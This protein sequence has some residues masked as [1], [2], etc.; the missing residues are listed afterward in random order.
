M[1]L[2]IQKYVSEYKTCQTKKYS[3]L[4]PA[5]LLQPL[6]IPEQTWEDISMDFL[7]GL[8]RSQGKNFII[9]VVDRLSKYGHFIGLK[10][11]FTAKDVA[12]KFTKEIVRL[13]GYPASLV[14]NQDKISHFLEG[15]F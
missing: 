2:D 5:G 8:L 10:H 14:S 6:P 7:E 12:D 1:R 15:M 13:H 9:V 11:P 4:P 3:T